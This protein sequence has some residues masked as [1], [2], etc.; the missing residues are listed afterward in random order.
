MAFNKG[1]VLQN[2][3]KYIQQGKY[4]Q[5]IEEYKKIIQDNP[6]DWNTYIQIGNLY[7]KIG[8]NSEAITYLKKVADFYIKDGIYM[9]AIALLK[10]INRIDPTLEDVALQLADLYVKQGL[11]MEAKSQLILLG[12]HFNKKGQANQAAEVFKRLIE[13]EPDN[14]KAKIELAKTYKILGDLEAAKKEFLS[15]SQEYEKQNLAAESLKMLEAAFELEPSNSFMLNKIISLYNKIGAPEKAIE[16]LEKQIK[17]G[18]RSGEIYYLLAEAYQKQNKIKETENLL[19]KA[20]EV[21]PLYLPANQALIDLMIT[22]NNIEAATE[23]VDN[24]SIKLIQRRE[25]EKAIPFLKKILEVSPLNVNLADRL[26]EIYKG[27]HQENNA[28]AVLNSCL[29]SLMEKKEYQLAKEVLNKLIA[30]EPENAQYQKKLELI[31]KELEP[32]VEPIVKEYEEKEARISPEIKNQKEESEEIEIELTPPEAPSIEIISEI[33]EPL[34]S[35][36]NKYEEKESEAAPS[37]IEEIEEIEEAPAEE[38]SEIEYEEMKEFIREH[39]IEAEVFNKYGLVDKAIEQ[40]NLVINRYPFA[41][42]AYL[43]LKDIYIEKNN[44]DKA[45]SIFLKLANL[46]TSKGKLDKANEYVQNAIKIDANNPELLAFRKAAQR[47][48]DTFQEVQQLEAIYGVKKPIA[49]KQIK[50]E[51]ES[52]DDM[53]LEIDITRDIED[54]DS[55]KE[56]MQNPVQEITPVETQ[57]E[58]PL[59]ETAKIQQQAEEKSEEMKL[60]EFE[61]EIPEESVEAFDNEV[62][63][64]YPQEEVIEEEKLQSEGIPQAVVDSIDDNL[65]AGNIEKAKEAINEAREL[66]GDNPMLLEK[67]QEASQYESKQE[68]EKEKL[69]EHFEELQESVKTTFDEFL[70]SEKQLKEEEEKVVEIESV[71]KETNKITEQEKNEQVS[72][73]KEEIEEEE[74]TVDFAIGITEEELEKELSDSIDSY[75]IEKKETKD[76]GVEIYEIEEPEIKEAER[77]QAT[78]EKVSAEDISSTGEMEQL[79][80]SAL[81]EKSSEETLEDKEEEYLLEEGLS[82]EAK[83]PT[84]EEATTDLFKE[85]ENFFDL[86]TEL[87]KEMLSVQTAVE[88]EEKPSEAQLSLEEI[89]NEFKKGVEKQIDSQDYETRYNLGIAYKEMGLLDEAIAEF[90]I[91]SKDPK[92]FIESCSL[93]GVCFVEKGMPKLAIKW[94]EKGLSTPGYSEEEYQSLRYDLAQTYEL[95][96]EW[97]KAYEIYLEVYAINSAYRNVAQKIR[98]LETVIGTK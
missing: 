82:A 22:K 65:K 43:K 9:K 73:M 11:I 40:L 94:Y 76:E 19:R 88:A 8:K 17:E 54:I 5:A 71:E 83:E 30:F 80:S 72:E 64:L 4:E 92:K 51:F 33:S 67:F 3:Q 37:S 68:K 31:Q 41:E 1:K 12:E 47:P 49:E 90:Q 27:L 66:Y 84:E 15:I 48:A 42:E 96:G 74:G 52:L 59:M 77:M 7:Q 46:Y 13:L 50:T 53:E 45:I 44:K 25:N 39:L 21:E 28:I 93:L 18:I 56:I 70:A 69:E 86:A 79:I 36:F 62:A 78:E 20:I 63:E 10:Q 97:Q 26:A 32:K 85:E 16:L 14:I 60:E 57:E 24:L 29:D 34:A 95:I 58:K 89:F 98:E 87:E 35:S 91:A 2:A 6:K 55:I 75:N 61:I 23:L 81:P 38:L